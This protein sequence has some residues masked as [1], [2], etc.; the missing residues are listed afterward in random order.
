MSFGLSVEKHIKQKIAESVVHPDVDELGIHYYYSDHHREDKYYS[1]SSA[2]L[3]AYFFS[4]FKH[5]EAIVEG[6]RQEIEKKISMN[7]DSLNFIQGFCNNC[8]KMKI[9]RE[10]EFE[11]W[12]VNT[13]PVVIFITRDEIKRCL[14]LANKNIFHLDDFETLINFRDKHPSVK[15]S[16]KVGVYYNINHFC[17]LSLNVLGFGC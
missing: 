10:I 9:S 2:T 4:D 1:V 11:Q 3:F 16:S 14:R 12:G 17:A 15:L 5:I 8:K 13:A 6:V 7:S